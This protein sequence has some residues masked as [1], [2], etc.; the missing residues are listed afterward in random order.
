MGDNAMISRDA[1]SGPGNGNGEEET[2]QAA[3]VRLRRIR[4]R[5]VAA[6]RAIETGGNCLEILYELAEC[7]EEVRVLSTQLLEHHIAATLA[8]AALDADEIGAA[9]EL[10][11]VAHRYLS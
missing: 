4:D 8:G 10:I 2:R 7:R 11:R 5:I 3:R 1:I 9:R 6:E